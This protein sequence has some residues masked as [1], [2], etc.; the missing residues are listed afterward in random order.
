MGQGKKRLAQMRNNPKDDW[1]V[2]DIEVVCR[3]YGLKFEKP[4]RDSH[5]TAYNEISGEI[6]TIPSHGRIKA[7]YIKQ[8]VKLVD[9]SMGD[10]D[11]N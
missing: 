11:D 7:I 10:I 8:F 5:Y 3:A 4:H 2:S 9:G 6:L 1:K